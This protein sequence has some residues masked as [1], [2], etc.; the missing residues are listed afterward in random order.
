MCLTEF[1][2]C[3]IGR[4]TAHRP[5]VSSDGRDAYGRRAACSAAAGF[6]TRSRWAEQ[7]HLSQVD[8][9]YDGYQDVT[10][11]TGYLLSQ[12]PFLRKLLHYSYAK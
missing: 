12:D 9:T 4:A 7:G 3:A 11:L 5:R 2:A 10:S 1:G 6:A 8:Y